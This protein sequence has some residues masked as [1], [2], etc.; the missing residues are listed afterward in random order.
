MAE[1]NAHVTGGQQQVVVGLGQ[2]GV[3][4]GLDLGLHMVNAGEAG[5]TNGVA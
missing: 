1:R 5:V 3:D 4:V 2:L